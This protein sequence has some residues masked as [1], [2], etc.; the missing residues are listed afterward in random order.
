MKNPKIT[1]PAFYALPVPSSPPN[2]S[3]T[4]FYFVSIFKQNSSILHRRSNKKAA[5]PAA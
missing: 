3:N 4:H 5:Q 1:T 2:T